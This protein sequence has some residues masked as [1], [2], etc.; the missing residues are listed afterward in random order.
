MRGTFPLFNALS[1]RIFDTP[2]VAR[3]LLS[4]PTPASLPQESLNEFVFTGRA[5]V[6]K[7][8]LLN[9]VLGRKDLV[10]TSSKAGHTRALNFFQVGTDPGRLT[11]VDAPG[12][13]ERGRPE[14]GEVFEHYIGTRQR[15]ARLYETTVW[16]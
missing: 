3:F 5:N 16:S 12:Y 6:G 11:L 2:S 15:Y 4:S 14:W 10:K 13:G 8:S 9:S 7:S 1:N